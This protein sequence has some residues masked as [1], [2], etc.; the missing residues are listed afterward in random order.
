MINF[1]EKMRK[2]SFTIDIESYSSGFDVGDLVTW[3]AG[4]QGDLVGT[5]N[6]KPFMDFVDVQFPSG[7]FRIHVNELQPLGDVARA[8]VKPMVGGG[9]EYERG[10]ASDHSRMSDKLRSRVRGI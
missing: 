4:G 3:M 5:V 9:G 8:W 10:Q 2:L 7:N 6:S 1:V